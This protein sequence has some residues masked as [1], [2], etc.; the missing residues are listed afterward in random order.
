MR[1]FPMRWCCAPALLAALTSCAP[2][3]PL[4]Q[5]LERNAE[6]LGGRARLEEVQSIQIVRNE[7]MMAVTRRDGFHRIELF[8]P[9]GTLRY[10]EG[11]ARG[12]AW[13]QTADDPVR[14]PVSGRPAEALW[15]V[16]QWPSVLNPLYRIEN[17]GHSLTLLPDTV[18]DGTSYRVVLLTLSDGFERVYFINAETSLIERSRDHRRLHAYEES[19]QNLESLWG[20]YRA[21]NGVRVPFYVAERNYDTGEL[22]YG[23]TFL[24]VRLN[25]DVPEEQFSISGVSSPAALRAALQERGAAN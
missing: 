22:L 8:N 25:V 10:A 4:D 21:L 1:V 12:A 9:D 15:R 16:L 18:L 2:G 6:A 5:L 23:T 19:A 11:I 24:D 20:D 7:Q 14:R 17:Q 3:D 13:E